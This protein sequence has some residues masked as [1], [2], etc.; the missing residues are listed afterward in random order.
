[1]GITVK[2]KVEKEYE[3]DKVIVKAGVRYWCDCEYSEDNG[4]H[5]VEAEDDDE[6]TDEAMKAHIPFI[7]KEDIG[8]KPSD[9]WNIVIDIN[10][11]KV[12]GWPEGFCIRTHFKIC[13]DGLYQ[14]VAKDG[15]IVWDSIESGYYYV[16]NFLEIGD[17]GWGDYM[18]LDIDG[19]GNIKDWKEE[20]IPSMIDLLESD[21]E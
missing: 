19:E 20:A 21:D 12:L 1:M 10:S 3:L 13:D 9:Y 5:W 18:Y 11:G 8:Y 6:A 15:T 14:V 2:K 7:V 16:P 4:E 17:D